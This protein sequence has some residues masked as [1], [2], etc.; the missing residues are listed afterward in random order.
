MPEQYN[1]L[2]TISS[3][4]PG[5]SAMRQVTTI[6]SCEHHDA[7]LALSTIDPDFTADPTTFI[8]AYFIL[9][10]EER[11]AHFFTESDLVMVFHISDFFYDE[12]TGS[13]YEFHNLLIY[14]T[15]DFFKMLNQIQNE[16]DFVTVPEGD[17]AIFFERSRE[18]LKELANGSAPVSG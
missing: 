13:D 17:E 18:V 7:I 10:G 16:Y 4:L 15:A 3:A 1:K 9:N 14:K 2:K 12:D 5:H 8:E 6:E 11:L